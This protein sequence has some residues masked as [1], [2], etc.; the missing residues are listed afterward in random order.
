MKYFI[1]FVLTA[2]I[3][4]AAWAHGGE[5]HGDAAAVIPSADAAPRTTAATENFEL[6][7]VLEG[8]NLMLYL[9][10]FAT[11][12]P[13]ANAEIEVESGAFKAI[14]TRQGPGLYALPG[15][16]FA[17]PGRHPLTI[18]IQAEDSADLLTATLDI[19]APAASAGHARSRGEWAVWSGAGTLLLIGGGLIALRRRKIG[20]RN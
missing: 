7:A 5:D 11:N 10:R 13:V 3:A 15:E 19:A 8:K 17:L 20:H 12:E 1:T 16:N 6:V 9:D 2:A 4:L 14:A 18:S